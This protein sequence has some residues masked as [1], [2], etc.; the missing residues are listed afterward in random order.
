MRAIRPKLL[1]LHP[2]ENALDAF[3][4]QLLP[5][6]VELRLANTELNLDPGRCHSFVCLFS[7]LLGEDAAE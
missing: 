4:L 1:A 6:A 5:S 3:G 2:Q 7:E